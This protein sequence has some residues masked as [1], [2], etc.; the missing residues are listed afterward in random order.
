MSLYAC[1]YA[2]EFPA[3]AL[4]RLRPEFCHHPCVVLQGGPPLQSVCAR[5]ARARHMGIEPGMTRVEVDTF[6]DLTILQRSLAQ[7]TSARAALFD[8]AALFSPSAED[9]SS[10]SAFLAVLDIT[11]TTRLHGPP[12]ALAKNLHTHIHAARISASIA[13][14]H[15][16]HAAICLA[17]GLHTTKHA[18][19]VPPSHEAAALAPLPIAVLGLTPDQAETFAAWGIHTL[20]ALAALPE[21]ALIARMG[22]AARRLRQLALGT[23]PHHF[24]PLD[25]T[26]TYTETLEFDAPVEQLESLLFVL[27]AMLD[28]LILRIG[29][30]AHAIASATITLTLEQACSTDLTPPVPLPPQPSFW[31]AGPEFPYSP[32]PSHTNS[33]PLTSKPLAVCPTPQHIRTVRP[34]LPTNDKHLWLKLIHLDLDAHPPG[35]PVLALTVAAEPGRAS[36]VQMGLFS[37]QLPD[38]TRLDVALARIRALVGED[39]VGAPILADTH[40]PD[41]FQ[42]QPFSVTN[43]TPKHLH[44]RAPHPRT[45]RVGLPPPDFVPSAQHSTLTRRQV[46]PPEELFVTTSNHQ[47]ASF[48][49]RRKKYEVA[50]TY[51]PWLSGGDWW[52][53]TL[54]GV[55]QWDLV[56]HAVDGALL[57]CCLHRNLAHNRWH[58]VAL[59]D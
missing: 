35:A 50:S 52:N 48:Y 44:N 39:H 53:Q 7:E 21:T 33:L 14:A 13:T 43:A 8:C 37:P 40:R 28:Q 22:E 32:R 56:A 47:P 20:G 10:P 4:L 55:E 34:A 45:A 30:R 6:P 3:Q 42:L 29:S 9:L 51:G 24:T 27:G 26:P 41:A 11:G 15:N 19:I 17:R 18:L 2:R 57:C 49:F 12:E 16:F 1:I 54:W 58:L 31:T 59:Y 23:H 36:K 46:R 25:P 38:A 5:N